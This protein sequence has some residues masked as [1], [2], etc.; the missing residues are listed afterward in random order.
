MRSIGKLENE[1]KFQQSLHKHAKGRDI[2]RYHHTLKTLVSTNKMLIRYSR[3]S[4]K[5]DIFF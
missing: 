3:P 1:D 5:A 4:S 2:C